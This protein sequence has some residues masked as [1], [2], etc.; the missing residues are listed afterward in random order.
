MLT[1]NW[2]HTLPSV[3]AVDWPIYKALCE[4]PDVMPRAMLD[5]TSTLL[6]PPLAAALKAAQAGTPHP[7][8]ADHKGDANTD[9]F[10]VALS[11]NDAGDILAAVEAAA[12]RGQASAGLLAAWREAHDHFAGAGGVCAA[13]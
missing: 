12:A 8:P 5:R 3:L 7:K 4:R 2:R 6:R 13:G 10:E 11:A 9:M 1:Y